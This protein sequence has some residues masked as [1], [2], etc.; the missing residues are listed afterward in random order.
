MHSFRFR[1]ILGYYMEED[2][3]NLPYLE[4]PMHT[5]IK[6]EPKAY[7]CDKSVVDLGVDCVSTHRGKPAVP[8]YLDPKYGA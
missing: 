8:G 1:C 5:I 3:D 4:V 6:L 7:G 2:E